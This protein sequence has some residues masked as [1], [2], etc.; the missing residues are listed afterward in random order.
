MSACFVGDYLT[1]TSGQTY[2][3]STHFV[4]LITTPHL[5]SIDSI[6]PKTY[7]HLNYNAITRTNMHLVGRS[8]IKRIVR[9]ILF[10][11][12]HPLPHQAR[13]LQ[14]LHPQQSPLM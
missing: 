7:Y 4:G 8:S 5:L 11:L 1:I 14:Q 3:I 10:Q 6:G 12:E 13:N 2:F 9:K